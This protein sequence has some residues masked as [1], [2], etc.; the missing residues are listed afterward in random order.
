MNKRLELLNLVF[1][2]VKDQVLAFVKSAPY[3]EELKRKIASLS[4][5]FGEDEVVF[6]IAKG[7]KMAKTAIEESHLG[8]SKVEET[9]SI[10]LG[11][12]F[13]RV[14]EKGVEIDE[15]IDFRL[16]DKRR[17]FYEKSNL[18]IKK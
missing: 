16:E 17:W 11:G 5:V 9:E 10:A 6:S 7:D 15:T 4:D 12:F 18:Y 3:K 8:K 1:E 14:I 13:A 2:E